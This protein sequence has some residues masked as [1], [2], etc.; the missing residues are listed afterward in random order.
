MGFVLHQE[1][2]DLREEIKMMDML[3]SK[4]ESS[5]GNFDRKGRGARS[6]TPTRAK[7]K[8]PNSV[9]PIE[10]IRPGGTYKKGF[11]EDIEKSKR[12]EV[13]FLKA[14]MKD[15]LELLEKEQNNN[16]ALTSQLKRYARR[17]DQAT[18]FKNG[19][20]EF[21]K[22]QRNA[23]LVFRDN[24]TQLLKN[25]VPEAPRRANGRR[26]HGSTRPH[27]VSKPPSSGSSLP[28]ISR[29]K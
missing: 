2:S 3:D 25:H 12:Q 10:F 16:I 26:R 15:L 8:L 20:E 11:M 14:K 7:K 24:Y 27:V 28:P 22:Q 17:K 23:D 4:S 18:G 19:F 5:F 13:A 21:D 6:K 29:G 1:N 9:P